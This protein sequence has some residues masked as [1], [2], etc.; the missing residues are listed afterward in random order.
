MSTF[1]LQSLPSPAFPLADV[2]EPQLYREQF[3]YT[4]VP[5]ILFDG[6]F[7]PPD[8]ADDIWITDTS[9]RDGQQARP[10]YRPEQIVELYRL[11]HR[12]GGPQGLIR[13]CEFFV[14]S[15][16]DREA[17]A[18]CQ[19]LGYEFPQITGWIRAN[20]EDF[21][22]VKALGLAETGILTSVSDY[23]IFL[24]L[25]KSRAKAMDEYL[26]I[27][28]AALAEGIIPRCHFEDVTRGDIR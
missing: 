7:L 10:P 17:L 13:Q 28:K 15:K 4:E 27:V 9:F 25:K 8:P 12:L 26:G 16:R 5:R 1:H 2:R 6:T 22:L 14:Y 11:M 18:G 21:K 19:A 24:K 3:P 20:A 23:H